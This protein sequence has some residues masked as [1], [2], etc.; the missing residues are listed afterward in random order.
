MLLKLTLLLGMALLA[1]PL[2]AQDPEALIAQLRA[3]S[4]AELDAKVAGWQAAYEASSE[5]EQDLVRAIAGFARIDPEL[6]ARHSAWVQA[7]PKSYVAV[8]ARAVYWHQRA[9]AA[10]G[11]AYSGETVKTRFAEMRRYFERSDLDLKASL[12]LSPR[13]QLSYRYLINSAMARGEYG[14]LQRAYEDALRADP[15]NFS[16]RRAYLHSLRPE[17]GG[18]V[19]AME[20][21]IAHTAAG[22]NTPKLRWVAS[23]MKA[24]LLGFYAW[25]AEQRKDYNGALDLLRQALAEAADGGLYADRGRVLVELGRRDEAFRDFE[26]ALALDPSSG[27]ALERRGYIY[28]QR[29]QLAEAV[30]DYARAASYGRAW[31]VQKLGLLYLGGSGLPANDAEAAR[32]LRLGTELGD[33]RAQMGLGYL[34]SAGRG[35]PQDWKKAWTLWRMSASQGNEQAQKYLD[36]MPWYTRARYSMEELFSW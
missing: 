24:Q 7:R 21:F 36:G 33:A 32:W 34:Y 16:A 22:A 26:S 3:G 11:A 18:S 27:A 2:R 20:K 13:P 29:K 15:E 8:L 30:Q 12:A 1:A 35:V 23:R 4:Y 14:E 19:L 9:W 5:R 31:P 28:E 17:W 10:R 25:Q 6:E